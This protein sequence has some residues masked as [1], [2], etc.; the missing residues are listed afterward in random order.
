MLVN[1]LIIDPILTMSAMLNG[2]LCA[3]LA[4]LYIMLTSR[5]DGGYMGV[6][7]AFSFLTGLQVSNVLFT[8]IKSGVATFCVAMAWSPEVLMEDHPALYTQLVHFY[9]QLQTA[10]YGPGS[11]PEG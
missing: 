2:Y 9:P 1:D 4:Y 11:Q 7:L 5:I 8:P 10:V 6:I 3:L